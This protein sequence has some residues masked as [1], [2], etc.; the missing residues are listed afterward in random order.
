ML[1]SRKDQR[2]PKTWLQDEPWLHPVSLKPE[3]EWTHRIIL[4][5][6]TMA[7]S[8]TIVLLSIMSFLSKPVCYWRFGF[9][10]EDIVAVNASPAP[11]FFVTGAPRV[12]PLPVS[13]VPAGTFSLSPEARV[14]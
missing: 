7:A 11:W 2:L 9:P 6:R 5:T 13:Q 14:M 1:P 12:I 8:V 4:K 10:G 3:M